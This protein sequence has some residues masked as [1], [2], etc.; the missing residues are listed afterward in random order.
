MGFSL[1]TMSYC[2]NVQN[3]SVYFIRLSFTFVGLCISRVTRSLKVGASRMVSETLTRLPKHSTMLTTSTLTAGHSWTRAI[4]GT[5][6][7][8]R[9]FGVTIPT[10][11]LLGAQDV[12]IITTCVPPV[13][14]KLALWRFS[15]FSDCAT[16]LPL[17][18]KPWG[19][20]PYFSW[21]FDKWLTHT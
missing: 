16:N 13:A 3:N 20:L 17:A 14:T 11:S 5:G 21:T 19:Y 8:T 15:V 12:V 10:S 7:V 2:N 1:G 18:N 4:P 6:Y 9:C